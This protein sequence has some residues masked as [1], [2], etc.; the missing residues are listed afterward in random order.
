MW[1][2]DKNMEND[3]NLVDR[4]W[5]YLQSPYT[6]MILPL[7]YNFEWDLARNKKRRPMKEVR[8]HFSTCKIKL[9]KKFVYRR[10]T[11]A[12]YFINKEISN[13]QSNNWKLLEDEHVV[14]KMMQD[15]LAI[16]SKQFATLQK[17]STTFQKNSCLHARSTKMSKQEA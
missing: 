12:T 6:S 2:L 4:T 13:A 17:I 9:Q 10:K 16:S 15:A 7:G 1:Q 11:S 8:P 14:R 5:K 3:T